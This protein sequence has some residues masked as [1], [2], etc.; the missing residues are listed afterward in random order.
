MSTPQEPPIIPM[1][2][3]TPEPEPVVAP[4]NRGLEL[5]SAETIGKA[6]ELY[7]TTEASPQDIAAQLNVPVKKVMF[8]AR[9][10]EWKARKADLE[11]QVLQAAEAEHREFLMQH[12]L[13][14][15]KRH[16][17]AATEA[18]R[19]T[20]KLLRDMRERSESGG[21]VSAADLKRLTEALSSATGVSARAVGL[22]DQPA[23]TESRIG[24]KAPMIVFGVVPVPAEKEKANEVIDVESE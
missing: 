3:E 12:R 17:E 13:P 7:V 22:T 9:R 6:Y 5:Y 11:Q 18:E 21:S 1:E 23:L 16:L 4:D 14:T 24:N 20:L 10:Y 2:R 8:W 15:I 19:L